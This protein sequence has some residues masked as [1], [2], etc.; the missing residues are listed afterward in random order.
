MVA[1]TTAAYPRF[2]VEPGTLAAAQA[3]LSRGDLHPAVRR[4][5]VDA[6]DDL[7][8]ALSIRTAAMRE[9]Q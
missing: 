8:R 5:M 6:T 9:P 3:R 7:Q 1:V 2:A 4:A